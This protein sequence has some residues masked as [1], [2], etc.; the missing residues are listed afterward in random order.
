MDYLKIIGQKNLSGS[1]DI[2]GAKNAAL[3]L[4]ASVILSSNEVSISNLPNVVD[5]QTLLK[6]LGM[7]GASFVHNDTNITI[8]MPLVNLKKSQ[9]VKK[10]IE[11][12]VPLKYTWSCYKNE[13]KHVEFVIVVD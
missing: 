11:L 10:A 4:L 9:I 13:E 1:V 12:E 2:S 6:L 8:S 7:L 3:P 5:I